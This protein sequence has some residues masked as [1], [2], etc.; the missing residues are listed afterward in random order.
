MSLPPELRVLCHLLTNTPTNSLLLVTPLLL[1]NAESC[2]GAL[3]TGEAPSKT[4]G[5]ESSVLVHKLKT[6]ISTLLNG[7]ALEGK[8]TAVCLIK[9][10]VEVGGWEVLRE[11]ESRRWVGGILAILRVSSA[12][13]QGVQC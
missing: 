10:I 8:F 1:R 5:S 2:S 3:S 11:V 9:T 4:N 6:K 7:K 13:S 12:Q